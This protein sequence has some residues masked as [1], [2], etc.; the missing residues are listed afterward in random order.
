LATSEILGL[1][2]F[3]RLEA[4]AG[5][6]S[7]N[8]SL[9]KS[10]LLE[11]HGEW[12]TSRILGIDFFDL[13]LA[14][15]KIVVEDVELITTIIGAILPKDIE[16]KNLT[17]IIQEGLKSLVGA[18]TFKLDLNILLDLS[19]IGRG[20]LHVDHS[21][22]VGEVVL[23][24]TFRG[25]KSI[26]LVR[27][28]ASGEIITVNDAENSSIN[29]EI[30]CQVEI[31]PRIVS[32]LIIGEWELVS[33][34]ENALRDTSVLNARLDDVECI[35]L[36]IVVEDALSNS[37]VFIG[38]LNN[39]LLEINIELKYLSVILKP[40]GGNSGNTI[41]NLRFT[42]WDSSEGVWVSFSHGC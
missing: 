17:V 3:L 14:I 40:L 35:I 38:V 12:S 36:K 30:C 42:T 39:W 34:Q 15:G 41:V 5:A 1:I 18:T 10:L 33:L 11:K 32:G 7:K 26:T 29:I 2:V 6:M 16:G 31:G 24:N 28:E 27:I 21:T 37:E 4:H 25:I 9:G 19:L 22:S 13:N 20:L 8:G 23:V